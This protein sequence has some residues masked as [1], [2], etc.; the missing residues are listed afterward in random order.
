MRD[1]SERLAATKRHPPYQCG[2]KQTKLDRPP[3]GLVHDLM[4]DLLGTVLHCYAMLTSGTVLLAT[5]C[6]KGKVAH[7]S[8]MQEHR[9]PPSNEPGSSRFSISRY[10]SRARW[11]RSF[12]A[13]GRIIPI[14]RLRYLCMYL[15]CSS[16]TNLPYAGFS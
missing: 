8:F 10:R 3:S 6:S 12:V 15:I 9:S 13:A 1:P 14:S 11:S 4:G 16:Q 5:L 7:H 2:W